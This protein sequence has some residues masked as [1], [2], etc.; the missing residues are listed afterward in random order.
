VGGGTVLGWGDDNN[1]NEAHP[2]RLSTGITVVGAGAHVP[3][4][5][6]SPQCVHR[7]GV[8]EEAFA[9]FGGTIPSGKSV[10]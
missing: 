10:E 3:R 5:C 6:G 8:D 9:E 2:D 4:T 7:V 1:V